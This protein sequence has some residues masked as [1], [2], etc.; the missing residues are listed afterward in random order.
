MR[1]RRQALGS[2]WPL[3]TPLCLQWNGPQPYHVRVEASLRRSGR[4][5]PL[6]RYEFDIRNVGPSLI[7]KLISALEVSISDG[8]PM[9]LSAANSLVGQTCTVVPWSRPYLSGKQRVATLIRISLEM[10]A[11]LKSR[12][13]RILD[14]R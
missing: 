2:L 6:W 11:Q 14:A 4:G 13:L 3:V 12:C 7:E 5:A 8:Q 1:A 9:E 10:A